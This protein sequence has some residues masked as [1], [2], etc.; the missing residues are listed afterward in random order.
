[1]TCSAQ[2]LWL[3]VTSSERSFLT[4][5]SELRLLHPHSRLSALLPSFTFVTAS[6]LPDVAL[7]APLP[8]LWTEP[9]RAR[10][11]AGRVLS[12]KDSARQPPHPEKRFRNQ[13]RGQRPGAGPQGLTQ[14]LM[15]REWLLSQDCHPGSGFPQ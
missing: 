12:T 10:P 9:G 13:H 7:P 14:W 4:L 3:C 2:L 8:S 6:P 1:M 11:T 15:R 5:L